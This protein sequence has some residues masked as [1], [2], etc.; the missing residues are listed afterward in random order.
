MQISSNVLPATVK[1]EPVVINLMQVETEAQSCLLLVLMLV[2]SS[3]YH[4]QTL[5]QVARQKPATQH[6]KSY[7]QLTAHLSFLG[8]VCFLSN[9]MPKLERV[10]HWR[11]E[12]ADAEWSLFFNTTVPLL[13][14]CCLYIKHGHT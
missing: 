2:V 4:W 11:A 10:A 7:G 1:R 12:Q 5:A 9:K 8:N 14:K 6:T 3:F 13:I